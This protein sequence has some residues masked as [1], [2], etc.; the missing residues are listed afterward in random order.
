MYLLEPGPHHGVLLHGLPQ[1]LLEAG[2]QRDVAARPGAPAPTQAQGRPLARVDLRD[3]ALI[4]IQDW[5]EGRRT[6][7]SNSQK[8]QG[9]NM[10][11]VYE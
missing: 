9:T 3:R 10:G 4:F 6:A 8:I 5:K 7:F 1:R 2:D 11:C